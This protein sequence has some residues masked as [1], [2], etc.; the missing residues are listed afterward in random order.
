MSAKN[1]F[2]RA[3]EQ[4][5]ERR[6]SHRTETGELGLACIENDD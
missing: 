3:L 2:S 1:M 5:E 6:Q 4:R